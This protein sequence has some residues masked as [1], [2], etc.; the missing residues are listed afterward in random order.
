MIVAIII[1]FFCCLNL[2]ISNICF[3]R[4]LF[5]D[6]EGVDVTSVEVRRYKLT[7]IPL[8]FKPSEENR[9]HD[10]ILLYQELSN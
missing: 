1:S 4:R 5:L 10:K 3:K 8:H 6:G 9:E 7:S 2:L